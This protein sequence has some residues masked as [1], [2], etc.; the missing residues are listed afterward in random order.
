MKFKQL[1]I[2]LSTLI[3]SV[4]CV[5]EVAVNQPASEAVSPSPS[6]GVAASTSPTA[7]LPDT[8]EKSGTFVKGEAPTEGT[9]QVV[10]ENSKYYLDLGQTFKTSD[11]GPDL[12]VI[13]HRS[14]DVYFKRL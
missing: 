4:G 14:D 12:F 13:L 8:A 7:P 10:N 1:I 3:L 11:A 2:L 9:A 6:S 5:K